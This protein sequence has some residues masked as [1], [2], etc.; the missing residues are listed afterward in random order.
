MIRGV[1]VSGS[2]GDDADDDDNNDDNDDGNVDNHDYDGD[3]DKDD[4]KWW[5]R[6]NT[7][8]NN[9][10]PILLRTTGQVFLIFIQSYRHRQWSTE[11]N[12][13]NQSYNSQRPINWFMHTIAHIAKE[14]KIPLHQ[15][16]LR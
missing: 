11:P 4:K 13:N 15:P 7:E 5:Q 1:G 3:D 6:N 9:I 16:E 10:I 14:V 8:M 2:G 12:Y